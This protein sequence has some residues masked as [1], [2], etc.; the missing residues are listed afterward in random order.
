MRRAGEG[1]GLINFLQGNVKRAVHMIGGA[2]LTAM[3]E[4]GT[5]TEVRY[6]EIVGSSWNALHRPAGPRAG[7]LRRCG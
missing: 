7:F 3:A 6:L 2:L 4:S 1:L 5:G